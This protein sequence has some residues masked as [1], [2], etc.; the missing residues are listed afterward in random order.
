M[1]GIPSKLAKAIERQGMSEQGKSNNFPNLLQQLKLIPFL[2]L[3]LYTF[4][5]PG[6]P[7]SSRGYWWTR[8]LVEENVPPFNL[9]TLKPI[10]Q[11]FGWR[12]K[13]E[14]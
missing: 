7:A 3:F 12:F 10:Y 13:G 1:L 9:E 5:S 6:S 2:R 4:S 11:K 14:Q 8:K